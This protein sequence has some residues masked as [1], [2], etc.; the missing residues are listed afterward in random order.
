MFSAISRSL[1]SAA[2]VLSAAVLAGTADARQAV[3]A[4][5]VTPLVSDGAATPA[6]ATDPSL[7]NGWGVG[8]G[9]TTPWWLTDNGTDVSTLYSGTGAKTALT[10]RPAAASASPPHSI[11]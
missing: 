8:A 7:V 6:A 4:F 3:G 1:A 5:A 10:V 9:P 11:S 2:I